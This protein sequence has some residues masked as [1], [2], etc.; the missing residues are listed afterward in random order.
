M[1]ITAD[2][3][4]CLNY[5]ILTARSTVLLEKLTGVQLVKKF[6]A[7]Y[8]TPKF[9]HECPPTV[10]N[11][12]Q[13]YPAHT[14]TSYLRSIL[15]LSSHLL[16]GLQTGIFPSGFP[17]KTL[18][19]PLLFPIRPT[20]LTHLNLLDFLTRTVLSEEYRSLSS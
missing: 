20:C 4:T 17:T 9:I 8:G 3:L 2:P 15:M 6:P 12:S 1:K 10:R 14:A 13:L 16:L 5:L 11:L 19:T 7:I 18:Y